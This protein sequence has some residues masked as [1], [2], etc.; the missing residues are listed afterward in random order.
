MKILRRYILREHIGPFVAAS[1]VLTGLMLLNQLAKRF[2]DLVGKGL[3]WYVIGEVFGLSVPFIVAMTMP[4]AVLVAV[5]YT[6]SRLSSDNE[7]TAVKAGGVGILRLT[8]PVLVA[9]TVVAVAMVAFNDRVLPE[10]NHKL[11][12]L[13]SD[14]GRKQPTFELRERVINEIVDNQLFLQAARIDRLRSVLWDLVIFDVGRAN[15]SRTTYADSGYMAFNET[16]TDLYLTLYDGSMHELDTRKP[17]LAQR[18]YYSRQVIRV[19][20]VTNELERGRGADWRGDREMN[21][22]MMRAQVEERRERLVQLNDTLDA[23]IALANPIRVSRPEVD[24]ATQAIPLDA[25]TADPPDVEGD[26]AA[27]HDERSPDRPAGAARPAEDMQT[28]DS[29]ERRTTSAQ[30]LRTRLRPARRPPYPPDGSALGFAAR[31]RG[32]LE[33]IANRRDLQRREFNR[34]SV[35]IQKKYAI[36]VAAIVFVLIGAP[37]G[38]RFPR[39]G[40][41]MV[42]GVSLTVF[43]VYYVFLI[44]GEEFAD[45][46]L[47]SPFWAMWTPNVIFAALGCAI[48]YIVSRSGTRRVH[49]ILGRLRGLSRSRRRAAADEAAA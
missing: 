11:R 43:S 7:I 49:P 38:V 23:L 6:F 20:G 48:L 33:R 16:Q 24:R 19:I 8:L 21:I 39:G 27:A 18:T 36:P 14:I 12:T 13:L 46:N 25:Q 3:P 45:R 44:G 9:S 22:A 32:E 29:P 15:T 10:S 35:E 47:V 37:I 1:G 30:E 26:E 31:M 2:G 41:G 34:Y 42:I 17:S 5:L 4:M 40:I 28:S